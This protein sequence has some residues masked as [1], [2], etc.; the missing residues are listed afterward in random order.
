MS[1][2][3]FIARAVVWAD[4]HAT[5]SGL[6]VVGSYARGTQTPESDL[7]LVVIADQPAALLAD[8]E[9]LGAFGGLATVEIEE[10]GVTTSVFADYEG[11]LEVEFGIASR[12]WTAL[13]LDSGT[14][15]VIRDGMIIHY[16][17]DELLRKAQL[18]AAGSTH[19]G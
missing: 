14:A 12:Q 11:N 7:D 5:V 8:L 16:D 15:R 19:L 2:E 3:K 18:A 1:P 10:Y 6:A 4:H 9:W 13:P 17:P